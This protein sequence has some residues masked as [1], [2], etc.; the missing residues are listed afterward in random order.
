MELI[1]KLVVPTF[2]VISIIVLGIMI[3]KEERSDAKHHLKDKESK[4]V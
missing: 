1:W 3:Y 4:D 2:V